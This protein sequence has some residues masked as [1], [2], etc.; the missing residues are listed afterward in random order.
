MKFHPAIS[1]ALG[2]ITTFVFSAIVGLLFFYGVPN[3]G[4][5]SSWFIPFVIFG[6]LLGGF[7]ATN[8]AKEM[9]IRYSIYEGIIMGVLV[10]IP[11]LIS[12]MYDIWFSLFALVFFS[13]I[14]GV[15]GYIAKSW[16][17]PIQKTVSILKKDKK[18]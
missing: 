16:G 2:V 3:F 7:I 17:K 13:L 10:F 18:I 6:F 1:I 9:K 14:S 15:G 8:F 4:I 5:V 11:G 12:Q